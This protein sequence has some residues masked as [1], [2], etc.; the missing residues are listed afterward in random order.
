MYTHVHSGWNPDG[1]RV[2]ATVS[3]KSRNAIAVYDKTSPEGGI[4][5][6][7]ADKSNTLL[8]PSEYYNAIE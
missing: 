1:A 4:E 5:I 2:R 3:E 8:R 6:R 7:F